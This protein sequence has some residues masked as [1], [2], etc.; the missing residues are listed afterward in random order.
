MHG[1]TVQFDGAAELGLASFPVPPPEEPH[2]AGVGVRFSEVFIQC[3]RRL[4]G[5]QSPRA[6]RLVAYETAHRICFV[7]ISMC[8]CESRIGSGRF[9]EKRCG[10]TELVA[11][12][13]ILSL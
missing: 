2:G 6:H 13:E 3:E 11:I 8:Q 1:T 4:H 9:R 7:Q 10:L 12:E 5:G